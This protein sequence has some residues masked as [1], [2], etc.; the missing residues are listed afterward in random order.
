MP[1]LQVATVAAGGRAAQGDQVGGVQLTRRIHGHGHDVVNDEEGARTTS[2]ASREAQQVPTAQRSPSGGA[3]GPAIAG[4]ALGEGAV[5]DHHG[6]PRG[7]DARTP[8]GIPGRSL[9]LLESA[10]SRSLVALQ[11]SQLS[12]RV[13]EYREDFRICASARLLRIDYGSTSLRTP[14]HCRLITGAPLAEHRSKA[15]RLPG[16]GLAITGA[17][18]SDYRSKAERSPG[19]VQR[20]TERRARDHRR[21]RTSCD[22]GSCNAEAPARGQGFSL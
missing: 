11:Q 19:D 1:V 2:G 15:E 18:P 21:T 8:R 5:P 12:S 4:P 3:L 20:N 7:L 14:G 6:D 17:R 16:D 22:R 10:A 13:G 9:Q